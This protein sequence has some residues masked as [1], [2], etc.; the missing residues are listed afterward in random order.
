MIATLSLIFA[1]IL[2]AVLISFIVLVFRALLKYIRSDSSRQDASRP[3]QNDAA[4]KKPLCEILKAERTARRMT[5]EYVAEQIG[6]SRQ[7]VSKWEQG[8]SEP[9]ASNL[10]ALSRL[11]GLSLDELLENV[12]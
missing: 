8:T 5:Q 4:A 1:L 12:K 2:L 6:V 10:L 11:Y 9:N 3:V 7:A